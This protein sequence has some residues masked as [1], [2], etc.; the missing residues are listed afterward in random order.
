MSSKGKLKT[1]CLYKSLGGNKVD[2]GRCASGELAS[3]RIEPITWSE[4]LIYEA[5][6]TSFSRTF[7][8]AFSRETGISALSMF[9]E[10]V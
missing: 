3:Y 2:Y 6:V 9:D 1:I 4:R 5:Y 7:R 8:S 10:C